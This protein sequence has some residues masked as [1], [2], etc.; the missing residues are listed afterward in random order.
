[1]KNTY[2]IDVT[3]DP[4]YVSFNR[5]YSVQGILANFQTVASLHT[6]DMGVSSKELLLKSNAIWVLTR[7]KVEIDEAPGWNEKVHIVTIP[8]APGAVRY[9]RDCLFYHNGKQII[10]LRSEWC[11]LDH[12][13][14]RPRR[15]ETICYPFE[16]QHLTE[17]ANV[18]DYTR[19]FVEIDESC[20]VFE[21]K[22]RL[23]DLDMNVHMNNVAYVRL[24]MDTVSVEELTKKRVCGYEILYKSQTFENDVI[25]VYRKDVGEN[26]AQVVAKKPDGTTVFMSKIDFAD[27]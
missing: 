11:I 13:T 26:S 23:S 22:V 21:H 10:R 3:L 25:R 8:F 5:E 12:D 2:E 14:S 4:E 27:R 15:A 6:L 7:T 17:R 19:N 16:L 9:D 24:S 18:G 1:M 20:F